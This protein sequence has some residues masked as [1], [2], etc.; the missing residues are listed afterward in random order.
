MKTCTRLFSL[1][2]VIVCTFW[3]KNA[4][5][6]AGIL[7]PNDP[8]VVYNPA[9]PPATPAFG[10]MAKWVKTNRLNWNTSSYKAYFYKNVAFRLKFPKTY[11]HGVAD[12]KTYPIYVFF[13]GI[14]ERGTIYDNEFQLYHGG[15]THAAAVDA[16]KFDGFLLYIQ[17]SVPSGSFG[18]SYYAITREIIE[19]YIV[20]QVKGDINRV[21]VNGLSAGGSATWDFTIANPDLI[22][23]SLPIS[24]VSVGFASEANNL[25]Y[26]PMWHFQGGLDNNPT[27]GSS[28]YVG[29][30]LLAA[31]A[32]YRY[33]EYPTQG[34]GCWNSA[35]AEADYFPFLSRQHKANP[36]ALGGRT[37][38][39]P[40]DPINATLGVTAGFSAYEWRKDGVPYGGNTHQITVNSVGTY[41]CR[42]RRGTVW[43]PWSPTPIVIKVKAATV[44]PAVTVSGLMSKVIPAPDGNTSVNLEVPEGYA[45]YLWQRVGSSTTLSTTNVVSA[46]TPGQYRVRITEQF[47]CS[48]E[49]SS[50]FTVIDANGPNKPDAA[51]NLVVSTISKTSLRLDWS[52]NPSPTFNET[53]FEIYEAT[54]SG[55]P[56]RLIAIKNADVLTHTI[57]GLNPATD[58]FYMVRA[59]NNTAAANPTAP[60]SGRTAS[61]TQPPTAPTDLRITGSTRNSISITWSDA[62]DDVGVVKY[63]V[64][65]NGVKAY[66]TTGTTYTVYNLQHGQNYTFS[67][68]ARDFANNLSPFSNQVSGQP[69][70]RG[71]N[72]KYYTFTGT[73]NNLPDF[74]TLTPLATGILPNVSIALRSQ[75][76]NFAFLWEGYIL[77][78]TT[79]TYQFRTSS[80]DGSKMYLGPL[81]GTASPYGF[82]AP[83]IVNND[84]LHGTQDVTSSSMT[85]QAGVYPVAF[86]FYE[87]GGGEVM[88][89]SWRIPGSSSFVAIPNSAFEEPPV[90]NGQAPADPSSLLANAV[91]YKRINLSWTD[92]SNN[93]TGFEIWRS[94]NGGALYTTV[95]LAPA[96]ATTFAD[97]TL[98]ANTTYYYK[99]RAINQY[100]ESNLI[101]S[102]NVMQAA[103]KF[104]GDLDDQSGNNRVLTQSGSP[105]YDASNKMEGTHSISFNGSNQHLNIATAADDYLRGSY[106]KK[107]VAFWMRSNSNTGN[108]FLFD[109]GGSDDGLAIRLD[110][111]RL[112]AGVA[113]NSTRRNFFIPYTSTA[114]NHIAL[115]YNGNTLKLFLNG[116]EVSA[117][118]NL[119]FSSVGTTTNASRIAYVDGNNAFNSSTGRFNGRIDDFVIMDEALGAATIQA[120]MNGTY[121]GSFATTHPLPGAPGAPT[122]L[123]A[124]ALSNSKVQVTWNA[125]TNENNYELYR[126]S[127]NNS[128]FVLLSTL[129]AGTTSY[130]DSSLFSNAI[131][132]YKVRAG[133]VGG[134]SAYTNEDSAKTRNNIPQLTAIENQY[135]R[136]GTSRQLNLSA[137]DAD[138]EVLT[139]TATG[140]PAFASLTNNGNGSATLQINNAVLGTYNN[141]EIKVT[142]Q[143]GGSSTSTFNLVVNSNYPPTLNAITN[144]LINEK[145]VQ[146]KNLSAADQNGSD[147]LT[148][149]FINLPAFVT[150]VT[151][152]T[153]AQLSIAPGYADNGTY[154]VQ[155]RV[156][157][158]NNGFD[159]TSF[160][161]TVADVNPNRKIYVNFTDGSQ[162]APAPW[163]NTNKVPALNDVFANLNDET[164]SNSGISITVT[165]SWQSVGNGTNVLGVNSATGIYPAQAIRSAY[166][167]NTLQQSLRIGGLTP[168][169]KYN[170]TFL[171]SRAGVSDNR[172]SV[173]TINGTSV[174]LN[175]A[176]NSQNTVS[177]NNLTPA[178][179]GTLN[180]TLKN[181]TGSSFSYLNTM[182]IESIF[183]DGTAP[184]KPRN[185]AGVFNSG[186]INLSWIDAAYNEEAYE[187]YRATA[188]GGPYTLLNPGGGNAGLDNYTNN[189]VSGNTTYFYTVRALNGYGASPY[190]DTIAVATPNTSP[191]LNGIT[192][193]KLKT[194]QVADVAISATD[195]AADVIT[196][197]VTGLPAFASFT[198]NGNG[199]GNIHLAPGTTIGTFEN[200]EITAKDDKGA[201]TST[202]IKII[203]TDKDITSMYVN[204]NQNPTS[205]DAVWNSFNTLPLAG[206]SIANLKDDNGNTTSS[207]IALVEGW[208]GANEVGAT[209]GNNSGVFP[210]N[211]MKSAYFESTTNVKRIRITGL[212]TGGNTKY[213]LVFFASRVAND[214][215]NTTYTAGGT[216][217]TLNARNNT[218][219]TAQINGLVPDANGVIE[220][221]VQKASGSPFAYL[222]AM[223][224][225]SYI[226]NGIPLAPANLNASAKSKTSIQL[227]WND[228]SNNEDGFQ[229]YRGLAESGPF[230]LIATTGTNTTSYLDQNL[231]ANTVYYYKVRARKTVVFSTYSNVASSS[232]FSYS[233]YVNFNRENP[234]AAPWN[235]T[236]NVPMYGSVYANLLNDQ[237]N[238][239]GIDMTVTKN[240][241]GDNPFGVITGNNSGV[242]PDNVIRSTWWLDPGEGY[243][244]LKI[245]GL[246]QSMA[247]TFTFF[248]S[249][250]GTSGNRVTVYTINGVSASLECLNNQNNTT[251]IDNVRADDNGEVYIRV[252]LGPVSQFG[253]IGAMVINAYQAPTGS[254]PSMAPTAGRGLVGSTP[255]ATTS[256]NSNS[257]NAQASDAMDIHVPM[258]SNAGVFP[259]P[260]DNRM[261]VSAH[262]KESQKNV[263]IQMTDALGRTILVRN[264][265]SVN[266]GQ[267]N[268]YIDLE[269]KELQPGIYLMQ[270]K[271]DQHTPPISFKVVKT[272]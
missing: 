77:I 90:V 148:W 100:G 226:D 241:S 169:N 19:D 247:Y 215:R 36:W 213:N 237:S 174:Q 177:I 66:V 272:R 26:I 106:N 25:R 112:Y 10:T 245:S 40:G 194:L 161:I 219:N 34:H 132:Y 18:G 208:E 97:S 233:V 199:T 171:G 104:D 236:N 251:Q 55:G 186:S 214:T 204:F 201:V 84:G 82:S 266:Q 114:W 255:A 38:F 27:P 48:S 217:V 76:D 229:I 117:N 111:N 209:T 165:S 175:A 210:D 262:F 99:I 49:F 182:V 121:G 11:Q 134:F 22:A 264:V 125:A 80:D 98:D 92:N 254:N 52:D 74:N 268:Y 225:Q 67:V 85:L 192:D 79:G 253:Y 250:S 145:A 170:F 140:L 188:V 9:S 198:D 147:V 200:I 153:T 58:Y 109:I 216:S 222:N 167:S 185:L 32:N 164:G 72:A 146:V 138:P 96:N 45:N 73:W 243:G 180:M 149:S 189:G 248:G 65:V 172:T 193:I 154:L 93:E 2:M 221:T 126:S 53:N 235:N 7:N 143:N 5:S 231:Q 162:Q 220:F 238:P 4:F 33:K 89:V 71:L 142:D 257:G 141:I 118:N 206:R 37:E 184:A 207:S 258:I 113:S 131:Y 163:N 103:W 30:E 223:V 159:T 240:F 81:N 129:P 135:M 139:F 70:L 60:S 259:N 42:I 151:N 41:E 265:G 203:V 57:T 195:D 6:Q 21:L 152:N 91:S 156:E 187:V 179:D 246:S 196:L 168:T 269:N 133:N 28:R 144:V 101:S 35:W 178:G 271:G 160:L 102:S 75:N 95:G 59:V 62:T 202:I 218:S 256:V 166:W 267:W 227:T 249:R 191:L 43:S 263:S 181:G 20:P 17:S 23:G 105:T 270:I 83:A 115:V 119:G 252:S 197:E 224:I 150:P 29:G 190:S 136:F 230:S 24:A 68:K 130:I 122:N 261:T 51:I 234:A 63:D 155:A 107:T 13:H 14:G 15:Q 244:E 8:I 137:T 61:D 16:G 176:N 88:N 173:Y 31:G 228:K 120:L 232:T 242:Y 78:P 94:D 50:P 108:R 123:L 69:L 46:S 260:F 127:N 39:C 211:A 47:G 212:T 1:M 158:G 12:G 44:P 110:N 64:F 3:A 116:V 56:Y 157:D 183:D 124:T 205:L 86:T 239:T 128:T 87:Q 54:Q